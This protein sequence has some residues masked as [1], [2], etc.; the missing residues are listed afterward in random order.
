MG[1]YRTKNDAPNTASIDPRNTQL[2]TAQTVAAVLVWAKLKGTLDKMTGRNS[3]KMAARETA[4]R[5]GCRWRTAEWMPEKAL[6]DGVNRIDGL[7]GCMRIERRRKGVIVLT[8]VHIH[9][10]SRVSRRE[11]MVETY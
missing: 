7:G 1:G 2:R 5:N 11:R 3:E 8:P 4:K 6:V 10:I 9:M